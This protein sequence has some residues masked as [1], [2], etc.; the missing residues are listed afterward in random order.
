M[1]RSG[2]RHTLQHLSTVVAAPG[3]RDLTDG[4]LL[5]AYCAQRD[6]AAFAALVQ[7]HSRLVLAV[8]DRVLRQRED[9]E[10]VFQATFLALARD[11]ASVRRRDSI[12]GW[13][14]GVAR[15]IALDARRS[16]TRRHRH[17]GRA[18]T[19][20]TPNPAWEAAWREVQ[21]ILD[22]AIQRLPDRYREPFVLCCLEDLSRAQAAVRLGI[23]EGTVGSRLTE[24]RRR[25][26][27]RL[28]RRGVDLTAVLAAAAV[29]A[30]VARA[31]VPPTLTA[32]ITRVAAQLVGGQAL[33]ADLVSDRIQS[34]VR[35]VPKV[36]LLTTRMMATLFLIALAVVGSGMAA[37]AYHHQPPGAPEPR[38][39][40]QAA[41]NK[42]QPNPAQAEAAVWKEE[43]TIRTPGCLPWS[44]AYAPNGKMLIVGD[45]SGKVRAF[46]PATREERWQADI[47]DNFAAVAYSAD[48][49]SVVVTV[50][51]GAR[52]LDAATGQLGGLLE[53]KDS[54]PRAVAVFPD[55]DVLAGNQ[56]LRMLKVVFANRQRYV[57]K[58]WIGTG[59]PSTISL[60]TS[61]KDTNDADAFAVPLA[62]DP[63]GRT[64][65]VTGPI[66]RD[67]GKNILWAWVAG[68]N[69]AG[70]PGNRVLKGHDAVVV[71]AAWSRDGKTA[72]TGD[73][74]G[75]IIV[76]DAQSM[77]E[78]H[79][80]E[81]GERA[82]ALALSSDGKKLAAVAI[83]KKAKFYAWDSTAPKKL[84]PIH[85]DSSDYAGPIHACLAFSPDSQQLVGGAINTV[86]LTR[87][88]EL[89]GTLHVWKAMPA[90]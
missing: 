76:W 78:S 6:E 59:A 27:D 23:K 61:A 52:F 89:I 63:E 50:K 8:C 38:H 54:S 64:V 12:A 36:M 51:N 86:W 68:D 47:N 49:Q 71:S 44:A 43:G 77:K 20:A 16:A 84:E 4:E 72:V 13:L 31:D 66:D 57:V 25:L 40:P 42:S 24:A 7:R 60:S 73:A 80:I 5:H 33:S 81:L 17:E 3:A 53:E 22:Q 70:S 18:M 83:G 26:R 45:T 90:R 2:L 58:T 85:T 29:A 21:L 35:G 9:N 32:S 37:V 46:D 82:A 14:H 41:A 19:T 62:V 10:D 56:R 65:I 87:L 28:A 48:G 79:R 75:R 30:G 69:G 74:A 88:G 67:T 15:H 1:D 55:R 39:A 11:A 34:L